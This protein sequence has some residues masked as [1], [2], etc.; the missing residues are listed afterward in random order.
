MF[1]VVR[2]PW[3]MQLLCREAIEAPIAFARESSGGERD[4]ETGSETRSDESG[5][6]KQEETDDEEEEEEDEEE[7]DPRDGVV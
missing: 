5:R 1:E 7:E 6:V 3:T 2:S 4:D